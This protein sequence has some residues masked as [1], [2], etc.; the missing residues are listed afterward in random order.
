MPPEEGASGMSARNMV[1][2]GGEPNHME[3]I[4]K[5]GLT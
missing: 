2:K 1:L 5:F 4:S 3:V